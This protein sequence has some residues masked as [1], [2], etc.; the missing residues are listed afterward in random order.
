MPYGAVKSYNSDLKHMRIQGLFLIYA[1]L[2]EVCDVNLPSTIQIA[3]SKRVQKV[4]HR[5][6]SS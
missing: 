1:Q 4:F 3:V 6:A 2:T 5:S